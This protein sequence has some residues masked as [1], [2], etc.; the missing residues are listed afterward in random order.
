[1]AAQVELQV[2]LVSHLPHLTQIRPR[3]SLPLAQISHGPKILA[4]AYERVQSGHA[5]VGG[6]LDLELF[7][8]REGTPCNQLRKGGVS[9]LG[10]NTVVILFGQSKE[11]KAPG[12]CFPGEEL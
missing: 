7:Q 8:V 2:L 11:T 4:A 12:W 3:Y 9:Y 5:K 6:L 1:M 10:K